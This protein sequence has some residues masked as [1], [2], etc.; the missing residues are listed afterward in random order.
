[1]LHSADADM[2]VQIMNKTYE[3]NVASALSIKRA[4]GLIL[5]RAACLL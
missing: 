2:F 3:D 5:N 4:I 1:M